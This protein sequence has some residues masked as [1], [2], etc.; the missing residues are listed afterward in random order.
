MMNKSPKNRK[1]GDMKYFLR[2][3]TAGFE[4]SNP[5]IKKKVGL[6]NQTSTQDELRPSKTDYLLSN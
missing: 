5:Y 4:K 3:N 6:I 1:K 2:L